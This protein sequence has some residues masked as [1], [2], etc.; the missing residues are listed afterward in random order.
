MST[1]RNSRTRLLTAAASVALAALTLTACNG[2]G[3]GVTDEGAAPSASRPTP[4]APTTSAPTAPSSSGTGTGTGT[5]SSASAPASKPTAQ[6][7]S[8]PA[9]KNPAKPPA[10]AGKPVTCEGSTLKTVAA[11]L[12]RPVNHMLLTVTNTGSS[13][14][15]LYAYPAVRFGE[16]QAVPPVVEESH[17]QAVVTLAPGES[18][19]AAVLLS[20]AD[21]SGAHGHTEKSLSV[22][23]YGPSGSGSVGAAATPPLPAQGVFVD[24]S[25]RVTYWQ[26]DLDDAL[27]W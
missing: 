25:L 2:D 26:Q 16:A 4:T 7:P 24:D 11:P 6:H 18:G 15:H 10:S 17:P 14:C 21:G 5:G 8:E 12:N 27:T 22:H 9:A 20:A 13:P 1:I 23:F 19:Y 3:T